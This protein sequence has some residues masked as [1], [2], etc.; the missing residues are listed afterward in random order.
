[1]QKYEETLPLET[2]QSNDVKV[3]VTT[4]NLVIRLS[5]EN[6]KTLQWETA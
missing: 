4:P 5:V 6:K 3:P 2:A 1:M